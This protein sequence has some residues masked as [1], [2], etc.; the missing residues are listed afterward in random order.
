MPGAGSTTG[1]NRFEQQEHT[2]G[3]LIFGSSGSTQ[4]P[5]LLGDSPIS[6]D[7]DVR[8][9]LTATGT[10][11]VAH[12]NAADGAQ[13]DGSAN[14]P[15][16]TDFM[17]GSQG[18]AGRYLV[19]LLA[20]QMLGIIGEPVFGINGRGDVRLMFERAEATIGYQASS[21]CLC[22]P[23]ICS[24]PDVAGI[25]AD[26]VGEHSMFVGEGAANVTKEAT[27]VSPEAREHVVVSPKHAYGGSLE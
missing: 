4:S 12:L 26:E 25:S 19:P 7:Y 14:G 8:T 24:R 10:G 16:D 9:P 3:T 5:S 27:T 11:E 15:K 1:A 21:G 2:D 18:A 22:G 13:F 17:F 20:W 6:Y 23:A